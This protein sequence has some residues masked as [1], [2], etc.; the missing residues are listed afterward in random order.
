MATTSNR[1]YS[2]ARSNWRTS[3]SS[4][5]SSG[6]GRSTS[7]RSNTG[8]SSGTCRSSSR[9]SGTRCAPGYQQTFN[10]LDQKICAYRTLWNQTCGAATNKRPT[11]S[12]LNSIANWI[13]KGAVLHT[14]TRSQVARWTSTRN[15]PFTGN[16]P[17]SVKQALCRTFGKSTIKAVC[18]DKT[19]KF[20]V[21]TSPTCN[22][23]PFNFPNY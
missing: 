5:S 3:N 2:S 16:S 7:S 22:G 19:G 9:T 13:N 4:G 10:T 21:V 1:R 17:S 18:Q 23:R 11:P 20:I 14:I 12:T 8:C 15:N 6:F